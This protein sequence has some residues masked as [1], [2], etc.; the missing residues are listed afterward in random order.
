MPREVPIALPALALILG[1]GAI[2]M[3]HNGAGLAFALIA[4]ALNLALWWMALKLAG[5]DLLSRFRSVPLYAGLLLTVI[6]TA[7]SSVSIMS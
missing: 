6:A 3:P 5:T 7:L 1:I 4:L 2:L